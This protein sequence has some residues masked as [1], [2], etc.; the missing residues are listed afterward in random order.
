MWFAFLESVL[1]RR[2]MEGWEGSFAVRALS[3]VA[4]GKTLLNAPK[5]DESDSC[6]LGSGPNALFWAREGSKIG[7][8]ESMRQI[9]CPQNKRARDWRGSVYERREVSELFAFEDG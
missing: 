4:L 5:G 3:G 2:D 9:R 1:E 6:D 8:V 7:F